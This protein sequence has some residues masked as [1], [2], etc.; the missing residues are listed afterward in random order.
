MRKSTPW[1][2]VQSS[3]VLAEGIISYS[4]ASHGG[5]WLSAARRKQI[6][7]ESNF[8]GTSEWWE[9]D[10]DWCCPYVF[11]ADDISKYGK[12]YRFEDNLVVALNTIKRSHP[13]FLQRIKNW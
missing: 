3:E 6:D 10:C 5:I 12:A 8:L 9:E 4:T 11:F 13:A 2:A 1:G 7:Y